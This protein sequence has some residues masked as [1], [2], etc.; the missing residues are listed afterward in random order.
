MSR[1][2]RFHRTGGPEVLQFD[3]LDIGPPKVGEVR[4]RVRA[5][6]LNRAEAMFRSGAYFEAPKLPAR[7]GWEAAGEIEAIGPGVTGFSVGDAVSTL[8]AFS[9]NQYGVYGDVAIVPAR[10][11]TKHP[12]G[13]SWSEAA[14]IWMQY[15]TAYGALVEIAPLAEGDVVLITAASSSVGLAAIQ[16]ANSLGAIAIA[17]TRTGAKRE[18]LLKAGAHHVIATHEQDLTQEV[19]RLTE[20]KGARVAFDAVAG[21]GLESL[22][23]A[24]GNGGTIFEYGALA[25]EPTPF[26]LFLALAKSLVIRGYNS[27]S[28]V[29]NPESLERGK[30]FVVAGLAAG[31]LKPVIARTFP[32]AEIVEAHR[33][34]ESNQQIGKIVVTA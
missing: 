25:P 2:V 10:A 14:T 27:I 4:I 19:M 32:L 12:A 18:A 16:I 11:V 28:I 7:L 30:R 21:R 8:P 6:G 20:N 34:L 13:L 9:M 29:G 33:Y 31:R 17:I 1:I 3:E 23:A 26:P 22:A 15:L 5:L 24:V